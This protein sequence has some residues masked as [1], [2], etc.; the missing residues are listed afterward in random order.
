MQKKL[1]KAAIRTVFGNVWFYVLLLFLLTIIVFGQFIFS[2]KML[3]AS[4]QI[5]SFDSRVF[6]KTSIEKFKQFPF[7]FSSRLGGMPSIDA[8]FGDALYPPSL[9]I[10][11]FFSIPR[12]IGMKMVAHVFMAG[13][14]FFL[15]LRK[16]F[17]MSPFISFIG[18]CFYMFNPQFISHVYPGHDGKMFVIA[19]LPFIIW[20]LKILMDLPNLLNV[21]LVSFAVGMIILTSHIQMTYFVLWG[22][23]FY[24][25]LSVVLAFYQQ[26]DRK[27]A[28]NISIAFWLSVFTGLAV[29]LI[30]F[31]PSFMY[32][33]NA[34][35]V[36]GVEKGFEFATSWSLHWPE[37]FSLWIPEFVNSLDYY[38]GQ[39]AFKLNTEYAGGIAL[40][41][42]VFAIVSRPKP[43][44]FFWGAFSIFA[45]S[46]SLGAHTPIF[47]IAYYIIPGVNKFRAAS[48]LMFWFSF[49]VVILA[50]LFLKDIVSGKFSNMS[51]KVQKKWTK[52]IYIA[53]GCCFLVTILFSMKGFVEAIFQSVLMQAGKNRAF[54]A[55]FSKNFVP[56]LWL[57]LLFCSSVLFLLL[58]VI[59]NKVRPQLF[60]TVVFI[61]GMIDIIR[62]DLFQNNRVNN[63]SGYIKVINPS[64]YFS[65][66]PVLT[67]LSEEM[68]EAP[69]RCFSLPGSL[70]KNGA[71]IHKLEGIDGFHDNELKWYNEFRGGNQ[72]SNYLNSLIDFDVNRQPFLRPE[73]LSEGNVFLD[74]A[75]VKYL[76]VRSGSGLQAI[77]NKNALGR[78]SFVSDYVVSD[79]LNAID[80]LSKSDHD[81]RN[82]ILLYE[83]PENFKKVD[84]PLVGK[85]FSVSW[86]KYTPNYRKVKVN[87]PSN[88]FLR[89]AEAYYPG[90][91]VKINGEDVSVY[92]ADVAWMGVEV[93]PGEHVVEMSIKSICFDKSLW[94]SGTLI[95]L[96]GIYWTGIGLIAL[97]RK[98]TEPGTRTDKTLSK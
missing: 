94:V 64:P 66:D 43:W 92:Q 96:I 50:V 24:W 25:V 35:S 76:L 33:R 79:T 45:L 62:V 34:Y 84:K 54:E 6:L 20:R 53:L 28:I 67:K 13:V 48:M 69:F 60:V 58:G 93:S 19:W 1:D 80:V 87:I 71:G 47:H 78:I 30:Q 89:I 52:G 18:G 57:W 97:K 37:V 3:F 61:L 73:R 44:R 88:G 17:G 56:F 2:D 27:K 26:K 38:W 36:R 90:W 39:N 23:F 98:H 72:S 82:T 59:K 12:A 11:Q 86:E 41:L 83:E 68:N 10:N 65:S 29:G 8:M 46:Y 74:I 15:L 42:A 7:W 21:T 4:D 49:G 51:E 16:G 32:V 55:N 5:N 9:L 77:E 91:R 22:M 81:Y 63:E 14:F 40:L 70:P 31:L 75:N 85:E 95:L